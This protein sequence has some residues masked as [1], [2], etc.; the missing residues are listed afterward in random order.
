MTHQDDQIF[1]TKTLAGEVN[2]FA[3]LIDRYKHMVYT[4]SLR[5]MKS[6]EDAEEIAQDVFLKAFQKLETY[7]GT[8]KFSTWLYSITYHRCLDALS[9]KRRQPIHHATEILEEITGEKTAGILEAIEADELKEQLEECIQQLREE[10]A[11]LVTLYYLE[12]QTLEEIATVTGMTKNNVKV[13]IFRSRKKLYTIM[14][15]QLPKDIVA[16]YERN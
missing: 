16:R 8:S 11:F 9:R 14:A 4:L 15:S 1:I 6:T 7:K 2:A 12:E 13:K 3:V 5:M 10:D